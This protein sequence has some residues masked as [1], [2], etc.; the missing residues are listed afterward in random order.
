MEPSD[1]VTII[2][3]DIKV[4]FESI[5]NPPS[6]DSNIDRVDTSGKTPWKDRIKGGIYTSSA[7]YDRYLGR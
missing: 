7:E 2:E 3:T 6:E 5:E 1:A 4:E